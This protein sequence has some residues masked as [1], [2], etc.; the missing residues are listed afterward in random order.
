MN[1]IL[2]ILFIWNCSLILL[3][4]LY[5]FQNAIEQFIRRPS[6]DFLRDL[7]TLLTLWHLKEWISFSVSVFSELSS[8]SFLLKTAGCHLVFSFPSKLLH[9]NRI[10]KDV[11]FFYD[12]CQINTLECRFLNHGS[13]CLTFDA[14][15]LD[16]FSVKFNLAKVVDDCWFSLF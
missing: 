12:I 3:Y 4:C 2:F 13:W 10:S 16:W 8:P 14:H 6:T 15:T 9:N 5:Y 1:L 11:K 7:K